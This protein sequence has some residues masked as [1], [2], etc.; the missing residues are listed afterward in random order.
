[1]SIEA[2]PDLRW[3]ASR[4]AELLRDLTRGD[5]TRAEAQARYGLSS[6]EIDE[7]DRRFR[8]HGYEG[9][10]PRK[11]QALGRTMTGGA[12]VAGRPSQ[13]VQPERRR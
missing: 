13:S 9:L 7:W 2:H 6:D 1:M 10:R 12:K 5:L 4:K 8:D 11:L 3:T